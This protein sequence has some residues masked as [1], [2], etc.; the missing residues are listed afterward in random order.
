MTPKTIA[1]ALKLYLKYLEA[2]ENLKKA[3][4]IFNLTM[5]ALTRYTVRGWDKSL[6]LNTR[7][8]TRAET[9]A[10]NAFLSKTPISQ[11]TDA[12]NTQKNVFEE[13]G[14]EASSRYT[15]GS[16]LSKFVEW[17]TKQGWLNNSSSSVQNR[18]PVIHHGRGAGTSKRLINREVLPSYAL[19]LKETSKSFLSEIEE[20]QKFLT[21]N[22]YPGRLFDACVPITEKTYTGL[23]LRLLGWYSTSKSIAPRDIS[24][25]HLVPVVNLKSKEQWE[26]VDRHIEGWLYDFIDFL[27]TERGLC[28]KTLFGYIIPIY[29]LIRFQYR[30]KT[31][32]PRY[33]DI[34]GI[35]IVR[36]QITKLSKR[37]KNQKPSVD[38]ELRWLDLPDIHTQIVILLMA[39][40]GYRD[41]SRAVRPIT[42]IANKFQ[43]F[44]LWGMMTFSPP[45]RQQE[46]RNLKIGL[47]YCSLDQRPKGDSSNTLIHPLPP[48][49]DKDKHYGY[50][51]KEEGKWYKDT[52]PESYKTGKTYGYQKLEISNRRLPNGKY[53]YDYLEAFLYGY[54][55]DDKGNWIVGG[56]FSESPSGWKFYNLRRSLTPVMDDK[57][58]EHNYVFVQPRNGKNFGQSKL[59][60]LFRNSAHRLTEKHLTP[61]TL[62]DI[63]ATWFLDQGFTPDRIASLAYAMGHSEETLRQIYDRRRPK[64]KIRPIEDTLNEVLDRVWSGESQI[65]A[66]PVPVGI[67]PDLWAVLSPEQKMAF[68]QRKKAAG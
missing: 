30:T 47:G 8:P 6:A 32:D 56:Q 40:C 46:L 1:E 57:Y 12:I 52:P 23:L 15:Y 2:T 31:K 62:R 4:E 13:L 36:N 68:W 38:K 9:A 35:S 65:T 39:E 3:K 10:V 34:P 7:K 21:K 16:K 58:V 14:T 33:E 41:A 29:S 51:Y 45:R 28:P 11:L 42:A 66:D 50:L 54:Y 63:Y 55:R 17:V 26:E 64:D 43:H 61:H 37:A 22:N 67:D 25:N 44:L 19:P 24:L 5:T 27:E 49:R 60:S 18:T 59:S 53:F 20:W 48:N